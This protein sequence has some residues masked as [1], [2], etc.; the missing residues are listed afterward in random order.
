MAKKRLL[1]KSLV[2]TVGAVLIVLGVVF[3]FVPF[4]PG[5]VFVIAGLLV[6]SSEFLW[7][8]RLLTLARAWSDKRRARN[9]ATDVQAPNDTT[10]S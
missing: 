1:R 9:G 3:S 4:V 5:F 2:F 7:A 10:V 6:M 8:E